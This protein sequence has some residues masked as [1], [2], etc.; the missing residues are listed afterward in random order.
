M[1]LEGPGAQ[2]RGQT[3]GQGVEMGQ[4]REE[5]TWERGEPWGGEVQPQH[6][7]EGG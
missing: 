5:G 7:V 3:E 1:G 4:G 6:P 2:E